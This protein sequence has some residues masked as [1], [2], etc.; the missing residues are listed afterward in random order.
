MNRKPYSTP[1]MQKID[2]VPENVVLAAS[3]PVETVELE[4][5]VDEYITIE[6]NVSFD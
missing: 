1:G 2:L 4:V 6:N 5:E 3:Y